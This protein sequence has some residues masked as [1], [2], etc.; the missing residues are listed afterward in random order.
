MIL[1]YLVLLIFLKYYSLTYHI[2]YSYM[3]FVIIW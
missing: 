1:D 3:I 2:F